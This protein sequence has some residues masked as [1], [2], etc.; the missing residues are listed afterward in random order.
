MYFI[1]NFICLGPTRHPVLHR[2]LLQTSSA[3]LAQTAT[4][5]FVIIVTLL[6]SELGLLAKF[7]Q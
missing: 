7:A 5:D 3:P 2:H 6:P 4:A 1:G